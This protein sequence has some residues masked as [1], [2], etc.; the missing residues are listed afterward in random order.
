MKNISK[1]VDVSSF[2]QNFKIV[3][4]LDTL[5]YEARFFIIFLN[6]KQEISITSIKFY[7]KW[8]VS[9]LKQTFS[10]TFLNEDANI[11]VFI[12]YLYKTWKAM[13]L[14]VFRK[15]FHRNLHYVPSHLRLNRY[16]NFPLHLCT[17]SLDLT[18]SASSHTFY[19][20]MPALALFPHEF[21]VFM[22]Q[23][24]LLMLRMWA[25]AW[26]WTKINE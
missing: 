22:L 2:A 15:C 8:H 25:G 3:L 23:L 9:F 16:R 10:L 13:G 26:S 1:K 6:L 7:F 14:I 17:L 18:L 11:T 21:F 5:S 12:S 19:S 4:E 24:H 20:I